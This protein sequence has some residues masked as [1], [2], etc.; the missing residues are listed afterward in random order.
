MDIV[1]KSKKLEKQFNNQK[2]LERKNGTDRAKR[3]RRR[4]DNLRA[5]NVLEDMRNLP[6]RCHELT[7]NRA[8]QLSLD[9]DHPYRLIF[10][11]ANEPIPIK[12]DGGMD[13]KKITAVNIIGIEDT[14]E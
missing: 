10:E 3:I 7:G 4:L 9:L 14:H 11:P 8:G 1:F 2:L 12:L 5:V 13:W 6:G